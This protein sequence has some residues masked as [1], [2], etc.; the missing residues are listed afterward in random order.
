MSGIYM[1]RQCM[2]FLSRIINGHLV[3]DLGN[4]VILQYAQSETN[5][6]LRLLYMERIYISTDVLMSTGRGAKGKVI[7][8][9]GI[10]VSRV[11]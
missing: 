10:G 1:Q 8:F 2:E 3:L 6:I 5:M 9:C 7:T 4:L 11:K